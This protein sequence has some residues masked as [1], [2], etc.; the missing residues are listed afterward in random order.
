MTRRPPLALI[1]GV[2]IT[3]IMANSLIAPAIPDILDDLGQPDGRAGV[4]VASGSLPGIVIAPVIGI[5]AD[6]FGRRAVLVPCLVAFGGFG[7]VAALAPS[8][9]LLVGARLLMGVGSAGMIN[10]AVVLI[11]D[12]W[13]GEDRT[14]LVGRN[15]A[16][17]TIGLAIMPLLSGGLTELVSWRLALAPYALGLVTAVAA[18]SLLDGSRPGGSVGL[19]EQLRGAGAELRRPVVAATVI[20]GFFIFVMIFGLYLTTLPVFLEDEFGLGAGARG[21]MLAVPALSSTL[22]A[23]NL[24][25]I[26]A[27]LGLDRLLVWGSLAF[28]VSFLVLG[29]APSLALVVVAAIVYGAGEG[30]LVPSMQD[31]AV[32]AAPDEHRGAV[33]AAWVSSARAGQTSGPLMAAGLFDATS[34]RLTFLVGSSLGVVIAVIQRAGL[35]RSRSSR[36]VTSAS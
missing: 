18:W 33:L 6:R 14:R 21:A 16:V 11:G 26:R 23:F 35:I 4:L 29:T 9:E 32:S 2:T 3:G 1:F 25:A 10:L 24:A 30:A 13:T 28:F 17:L 34:T 15:A 22:V 12:H 27:R 20:S 5:L 7:I 36:A 31:V 8:F 19:V